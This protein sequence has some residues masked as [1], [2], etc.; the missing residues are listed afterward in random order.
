MKNKQKGGGVHPT[1]SFPQ[2]EMFDGYQ[3]L[4]KAIVGQAIADFFWPFSTPNRRQEVRSVFRSERF[5]EWGEAAGF[6]MDVLQKL[7]YLPLSPVSYTHLT[8]P[9]TERV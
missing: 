1:P 4:V 3:R 2:G 9:T 6:R 7:L 5:K 8:L